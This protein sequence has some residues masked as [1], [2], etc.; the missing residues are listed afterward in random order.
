MAALAPGSRAKVGWEP[1]RASISADDDM[2]VRCTCF[3]E[4]EM[5]CRPTFL[6]I[7]CSLE[8]FSNLG[9]ILKSGFGREGFVKTRS[10][11]G[12]SQGIFAAEIEEFC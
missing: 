1:Y 6:D 3:G 4:R 5:P 10:E 9:F 12:V 8:S 11:V 7:L 2:S